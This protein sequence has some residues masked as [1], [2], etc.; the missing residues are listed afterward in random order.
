MIAQS[1][2][3]KDVPLG[4]LLV[5]LLALLAIVV[6]GLVIVTQVKKRMDNADAPSITSGFTLS[7]LRRL[8][9]AGQVS[10]QEFEI[11]KLRVVEAAKR[12]AERASAKQ[13]GKPGT[14]D[15]SAK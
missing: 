2:A 1:N 14:D 7:D 6:I 11:A 5:L 9:K 12:A 8:H 13:S 15:I 10:D 4:S 3:S